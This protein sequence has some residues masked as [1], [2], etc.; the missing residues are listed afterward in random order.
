KSKKQSVV[1]QSSAEAE[2]I[3]AGEAVRE[4]LWLRQLLGELGLA[5]K[6][7]TLVYGDNKTANAMA[8]NTITARSKHIDIRHHF[9]RDHIQ[10]GDIDLQ[11]VSTSEQQADIFT[12]ALGTNIFCSLRDLIMGSCAPAASQ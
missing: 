6:H 5:P 11:W 3:A 1:A 4:T 7:G 9:V 2:Y 10:R 12:K 8:N